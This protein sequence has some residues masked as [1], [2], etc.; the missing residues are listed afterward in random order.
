MRLFRRYSI[1]EIAKAQKQ[2]YLASGGDLVPSSASGVCHHVRVR[3]CL[4][5]VGAFGSL[6]EGG[7]NTGSPA[8]AWLSR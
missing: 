4:W 1:E 7:Y 8:G 6:D 5:C 3:G 2:G